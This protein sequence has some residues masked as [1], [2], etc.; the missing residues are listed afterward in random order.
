M[1]KQLQKNV[2]KISIENLLYEL[3]DKFNYPILVGVSK[4]SFL[5]KSLNLEVS[6]RENASVISETIA[7]CNGAKIIRTHNV[8]NAVEIKKIFSNLNRK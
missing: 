6:E 2:T 7:C 3:C 5:G 4:K 8:K 1:K